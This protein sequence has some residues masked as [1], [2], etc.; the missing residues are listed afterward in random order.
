MGG[1]INGEGLVHRW[2]ILDEIVEALIAHVVLQLVDNGESTIVEDNDDQLFLGED[3]RIDVRIHQ[4]VRAI[5][6]KNDGVAVGLDFRLRDA[7]APAASNFIAHA[8]EA[9]FDVNSAFFQCSPVGSDFGWQT[10]CCSNNPVSW[11][12]KRVHGADGLRIGVRA[13]AGSCVFSDVEIPCPATVLR[14]SDPR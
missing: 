4:Q 2:A 14:Q 8:G 5:A 12:T 13:V 9:E 6:H 10:T 7:R 1:K 11:V 3:R